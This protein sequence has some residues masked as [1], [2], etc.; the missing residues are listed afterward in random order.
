M[1]ESLPCLRDYLH[2]TDGTRND[3]TLQARYNRQVRPIHIVAFF[4]D[5]MNLSTKLDQTQDTQLWQFFARHSSSPS[6]AKAMQ[7]EFLHFRRQHRPFHLTRKCWN[8]ADDPYVFWLMATEFTDFVVPLAIRVYSTPANSV[9]SEHTVSV[10]NVIH[11]KDRNR[12]QAERVDKLSFI[13]SNTRTFRAS[14]SQNIKM[15]NIRLVNPLTEE[16]EIEIEE[17]LMAEEEGQGCMDRYDDEDTEA[18]VVDDDV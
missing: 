4:L 1:Q 3:H 5:P 7:V 12:L 10:M 11:K 8:H 15:G 18:V 13:Y 16:E 2:F 14:Q 6:E 17:Q 9:P